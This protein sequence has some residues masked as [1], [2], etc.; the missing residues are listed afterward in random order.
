[1]QITKLITKVMLL[2]MSTM[3]SVAPCYAASQSIDSGD[4]NKPYQ[5]CFQACQ[6]TKCYDN[7]NGNVKSLSFNFQATCHN[8]VLNCQ[9]GCKDKYN[10]D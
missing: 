4:N 5:A 7:G 10:V 1:M 2:T 6:N 8:K 9:F 3:V